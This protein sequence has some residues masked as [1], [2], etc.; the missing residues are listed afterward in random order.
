MTSQQIADGALALWQFH[1]DT[2]R[3]V[4]AALLDEFI[5]PPGYVAELEAVKVA[6]SED[7]M[8]FEEEDEAALQFA[9]VGFRTMNPEM[10]RAFLVGA[11]DE[12]CAQAR[13]GAVDQ[14]SAGQLLTRAQLIASVVMP[15][16][17]E[18]A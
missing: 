11:M 14:Y 18:A 16:H 8:T 3:A 15:K 4:V 5:A 1:R 17:E 10:Q 12:F 7:V 13:E 6:M 9:L 2:D